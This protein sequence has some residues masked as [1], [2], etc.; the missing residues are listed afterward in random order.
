MARVCAA[1]YDDLSPDSDDDSPRLTKDPR[2]AAGGAEVSPLKPVMPRV[3]TTV[4]SMVKHPET[5]TWHVRM[6]DD[7]PKLLYANGPTRIVLYNYNV[8]REMVHKELVVRRSAGPKQG[9]SDIFELTPASRVTSSH[10][11]VWRVELACTGASLYGKPP[12][13][14]QRN[15]RGRRARGRGAGREGGRGA[16]RGGDPERG[17]TAQREINPSFVQDAVPKTPLRPRSSGRPGTS[18]HHMLHT[19]LPSSLT[20]VIHAHPSQQGLVVSQLTPHTI[21]GALA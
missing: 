8:V 3:L 13:N 9:Y 12:P 6:G 14:C 21:Q 2:S 19:E 1:G 17:E 7:V 16:P 18:V 20:V 4:S 5:S 15:G 11:V 10:T